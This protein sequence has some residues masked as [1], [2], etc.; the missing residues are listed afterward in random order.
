MKAYA[1]QRRH[2]ELAGQNSAGY[3]IQHCH[4]ENWT[5]LLEIWHL[6]L[7][8]NLEASQVH[9][10]TWDMSSL[11]FEVEGTPCFAPPPTFWE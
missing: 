9:G 11:L 1:T 6:K 3:Q 10:R 2:G 4:L 5:G 7:P 8:A